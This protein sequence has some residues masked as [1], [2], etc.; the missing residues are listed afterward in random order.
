VQV[1]RDQQPHDEWRETRCETCGEPF[2]FMVELSPQYTT[3]TPALEAV[4]A[5]QREETR[6]LMEKHNTEDAG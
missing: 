1:D 5:R 4:R 2:R 3:M 6:R